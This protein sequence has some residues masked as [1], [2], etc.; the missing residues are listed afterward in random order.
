MAT[1]LQF[2]SVYR[3]AR[4]L[5]LDPE[6]IRAEAQ[7]G[8]LPHVDAKG[9]LLFNPEAVA[10]ILAERAA[11]EGLHRQEGGGSG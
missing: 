3:L 11:Q 9:R 5:R 4:A 10:R 7:A 2:V 1:T 8:R 6:W